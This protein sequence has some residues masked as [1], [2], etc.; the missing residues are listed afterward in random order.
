MENY[1]KTYGA[2]STE[3]FEKITSSVMTSVYGWMAGALAISGLT[4]WYVSQDAMLLYNMFNSG[5][6][7]ILFIAELGLVLGLSAAINKI[8]AMTATIMFIL[9]ALLNGATLA[10]IFVVYELSSIASTFFI[11]AGTFG[12][13]ALYGTTTKTDL[14][15]I[16]NIC[17]MGLIGI[18]IAGVVNIFIGND[19][20]GLVTNVLGVIIF[21][22]LTAYDS[23]K[24]KA[25]VADAP[26]DKEVVGKLAVLGALTLYLDFVNLFLKLLALFGKKK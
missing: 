22:G 23:Q 21:V 13:L 5:A 10:S 8:S 11:T 15:K 9:Y 2:T 17:F 18:I 25:M 4:A 26:A 6:I 20:L 3:T 24:I 1:V 19:M 16:G 12:A 7:W 14:T